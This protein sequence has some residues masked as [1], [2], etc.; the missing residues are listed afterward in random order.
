MLMSGFRCVVRQEYKCLNTASEFTR[1]IVTFSLSQSLYRNVF[2]G[3]APSIGMAVLYY[4]QQPVF[5]RP[6]FSQMLTDL[7]EICRDLLLHGIHLWVQFHYVRCMGGSRP[8]DKDFV[9]L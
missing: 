5:F 2:D 8:N 1:I 9:F 7:D 6:P 4:K 3:H